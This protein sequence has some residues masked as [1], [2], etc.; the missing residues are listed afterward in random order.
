MVVTS[1]GVWRSRFLHL[2]H[3]RV[4]PGGHAQGDLRE[5][6]VRHFGLRRDD[7][8][9]AFPGACQSF[10]LVEGLLSVGLGKSY[11]RERHQSNGQQKTK[12]FHVSFSLSVIRSE[13]GFSPEL[14][15]GRFT[16][17]RPLVL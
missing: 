14:S 9:V 3:Q 7:G 6:P 15:W 12:G 2:M 1:R 5:R 16:G 4:S 8:H 11:G 13:Q 10:Q 17:D